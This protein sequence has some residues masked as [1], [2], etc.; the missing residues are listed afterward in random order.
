[1]IYQYTKRYLKNTIINPSNDFKWTNLDNSKFITH[2]EKR[3]PFDEF[4]KELPEIKQAFKDFFEPIGIVIFR[5]KEDIGIQFKIFPY[6][7][8]PKNSEHLKDIIQIIKNNKK[9]IEYPYKGQTDQIAVY[10]K[11]RRDINRELS[12]SDESVNTKELIKYAIKKTLNL[13]D[14]DIITQLRKKYIIKIFKKNNTL[15]DRAEEPKKREGISNR[16]NGYTPEEIKN[17]YEK[18]FLK[19]D[20]L[21]HTFLKNIMNYLFANI[22][23]FR[24]ITN[25]FY[26]KKVLKIIHTKITSELSNYVELEEDYLIGV[27]GYLM[28]INFQEIHELMARELIE[29]IYQRDINANK[30]LCYYNGTIVFKNTKRYKAPS[31]ETEDGKQWNNA[32]LIGICNLWMNIK[33]RR[34][35]SKE[36]FL[37]INKKLAELESILAHIKPEEERIRT[38]IV[39]LESKFKAFEKEYMSIKSEYNSIKRSDNGS[40]KYFMMLTKYEKASKILGELK[41]KKLKEKSALKIILN[42]TAFTNLIFF[43]KQKKIVT[44]DLRVQNINLDSKNSQIEPILKS[45][46]KALM[47]RT[48]ILK[49]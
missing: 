35:E 46:S 18:I 26:E 44:E 28:R 13:S 24:T 29:C 38:K 22:L 21:I 5:Y 16:Y 42:N 4:I 39:E 31:I 3:Y 17:T 10:G 8:E 36:K 37:T 7:V 43:T 34:N 45:I 15:N 47:D 23:N 2:I 25:E 14:K 33:K 27:T 12:N 19:D 48:K 49:T 40:D 9:Y 41:D 6:S 30:F 1:M 11:I 20:K 32:T